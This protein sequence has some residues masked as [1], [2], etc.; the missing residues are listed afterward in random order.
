MKFKIFVF[1]TYEYKPTLKRKRQTKLKLL[2]DKYEK[3]FL[4][5]INKEDLTNEE[6]LLYLNAFTDVKKYLVSGLL[7][8]IQKNYDQKKPVEKK[9]ETLFNQY[10]YYFDDYNEFIFS[11]REEFEDLCDN[12]IYAALG[13]GGDKFVKK[14]EN[15]NF[16]SF[17]NMKLF[18]AALNSLEKRV[19]SIKVV[20]E[21]LRSEVVETVD[22]QISKEE[23]INILLKEKNIKDSFDEETYSEIK[24]I[25]VNDK[26]IPDNLIGL[27]KFIKG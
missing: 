22:E 12:V 21:E 17:L 19:N 6:G 9:L 18:Y 25:L 15:S 14:G 8:N 23:E 20:K 26:E 10:R 13:Y 7:I 1:N 3:L 2:T 16:I 11:I 27:F 24:D 4:K 5:L